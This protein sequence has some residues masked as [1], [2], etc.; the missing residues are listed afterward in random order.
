MGESKFLTVLVSR[1]V[2]IKIG[3]PLLAISF[4]P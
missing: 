3:H 2:I 4:Y 1:K